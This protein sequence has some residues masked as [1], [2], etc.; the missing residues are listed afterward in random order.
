MPERLAIWWNVQ[1]LL[2]PTG[3]RLGRSLDATPANG[4][5]RAAYRAKLRSLAAVLRDISAGEVPAV[6]AFAEVQNDSV[7][8]DLLEETGWTGLQL[9]EDPVAR[10][11][12]DDL[13]LFH[14][15]AVLRLQGTP[16]SY[17]VHNRF[18]TRDLLEARFATPA[19][20]ELTIITAHW[21][22]RRISNSDALRIGLGDYT[23]RIVEDRLKFGKDELVNARGRAT[24]PSMA[25]LLERWNRPLLLMGDFND[26]PF[27]RSVGDVLG[28]RR[29]LR[30]SVEAP[31][32]PRGK[33]LSAVEA[34]LQ[35]RVPLY[36]P[37]WEL[38]TD[39]AGPGGSHYWDGNWYLLDQ[40]ILSRG[41]VGA[42]PVRYV[43]GSLELHAPRSVP[44]PDGRVTVTSAL[45]IPKAFD[46][47]TRSGVSDH[48]PLSFRVDLP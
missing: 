17:N 48:L 41:L 31:R 24:M 11:V 12:G 33:S 4:W 29:A 2:A 8:R 21:P 7:A 47:A 26:G 9:V 3:S 23:L 18:A 20:D 19:G 14:D 1:R 45:S 25:E 46:P 38:L 42:G 13:V 5:T 16:T 10:L 15:P 44:G 22:S 32:L 40:V 28:A 36:N 35:R 27:D 30:P 43:E 6:L 34:Y 37:T 39:A